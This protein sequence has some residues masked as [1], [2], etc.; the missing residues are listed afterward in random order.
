L[1][2]NGYKPE[3]QLFFTVYSKKVTTLTHSHTHTHTQGDM[4][5]LEH[6]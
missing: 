2:D 4:C 3:I 5:V 1:I 6:T